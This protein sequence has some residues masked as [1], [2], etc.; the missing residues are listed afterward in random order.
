METRTL[1]V[2]DTIEK[3]I[4]ILGRQVIPYSINRNGTPNKEL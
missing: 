2:A 3:I 1:R 4:L